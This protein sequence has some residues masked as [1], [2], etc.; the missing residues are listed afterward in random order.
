M[1][2]LLSLIF[3]YYIS[4]VKRWNDNL[5]L[6]KNQIE[7]A[8]KKKKEKKKKKKQELVKKN[9]LGNVWYISMETFYKDIQI[10]VR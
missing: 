5:Y 1:E 2:T 8:K 10:S 6:R 3:L 4:T 9:R 7:G